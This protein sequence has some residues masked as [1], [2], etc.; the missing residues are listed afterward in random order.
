MT[1]S[2]SPTDQTKATVLIVDDDRSV[3]VTLGKVLQDFVHTIFACNG[4]D[5]LLQ[6]RKTPPD[7]ILLDME[8]P[9][10]CG[11]DVCDKLNATA[12]TAGIPVIFIT[13]H[14][15]PG[16]EEWVF[17]SGAVDYIAKPLNPRIVSARVKT[18]LDYQR[19]L[20]QLR[21]LATQDGLTGLFNR[22][23]FD[24]RLEQEWLRARRQQSSL[25]LLIIGIDEFKRYSDHYGQAQG[26]VCL[27]AVA[28]VL[29]KGSQR[30]GDFVARFG[31]EEFVILLPGTEEEGTN[32][33]AQALQETIL[34]SSLPQAPD[35]THPVV[36]ISIG[37]SVCE[38][39]TLSKDI[40]D[41]RVII[42]AAYA[43]LY[44]A[45]RS[46]HNRVVTKS[47]V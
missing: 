34:Q 5:A 29:Q 4:A 44:E 14:V 42:D 2:L 9:D 16:I 11:L 33:V 25:A 40:V 15:E 7:L 45:K 39:H 19:A 20:V 6:V 3:I 46:D 12:E 10:M 36:T 24:E 41:S 22:R 47:I 35:T 13:S 43:A 37:C 27:R 38:P 17:Q 30:A 18:H 31:G 1:L 32:R 21:D 28:D 26:D 8:M 23:A